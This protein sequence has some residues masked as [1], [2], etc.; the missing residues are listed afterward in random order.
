MDVGDAHDA[1]TA[2]KPTVSG[3]ISLPSRGSFHPSLTVLVRYR[4]PACT[5][6]YEVVLADSHGLSRIPCYSG[7]PPGG[8]YLS[9]TGPLPSVARLSRTLPLGID[10]VTPRSDCRHSRRVP[11]PRHSIAG[12][13]YHCGGLGSSR[14][15]RRYSGSRGCFPF[16]GVL[17]CFNSPGALHRPYVFRPG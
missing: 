9:C 5:Q 4:S 2:C 17:R 12:R 11:R 1:L 15:A 3:S 10:L 7:I 8:R 16:L 14:F 13:L 6:P